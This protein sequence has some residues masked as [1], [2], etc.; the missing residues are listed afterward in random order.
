MFLSPVEILL[1]LLTGVGHLNRAAAAVDRHLGDVKHHPHLLLDDDDD[2]DGDLGCI[3]DDPQLLLLH[4]LSE[5]AHHTHHLVPIFKLKSSLG[6]GFL[7]SWA[8]HYI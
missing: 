1:I 3:E 7:F 2:D 4:S 6:F 5:Q 8:I